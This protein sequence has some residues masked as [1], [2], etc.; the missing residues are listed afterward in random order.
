MSRPLP[1]IEVKDARF[2]YGRKPVLEGVTLS[3]PLGQ[4]TVLLGANGEGK[5]TLLRLCLGVLKPRSGE[6]RVMG[7]DPVRDAR[8]VREHVGFVPDKPDV[9]GWMTTPDLFRFLKPHY[10]TWSDAR[11]HEVAEQLSVPM[12]TPFKA[13]SRGQG[14][15]AMLAAALGHDPEVLLLDEPFGGLDPLVREEVL[16]NVI[17]ALGGR[18]RSVLLVTHD[19]DVAARV[20]DRVAVLADGVIRKEGPAAEVAGR[21]ESEATPQGL[22]AALAVAA[23]ARSR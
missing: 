8:R 16:R 7:L 9:Y 18:L 14:M 17:A 5:T 3:V 12:T 21:P 10:G 19:L 20:A 23:G 6:V 13:M 15:K 11:A 2:R 1:A 22:H 4:T